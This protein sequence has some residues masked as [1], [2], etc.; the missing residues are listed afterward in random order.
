MENVYR[1]IRIAQDLTI[2]QLSEKMGISSSYINEIENGK[3]KASRNFIEKFSEATGIKKSTIMYFE[4]E[5]SEKNY[6]YQDL[7]LRILQKI[8]EM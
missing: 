7:L 5:N 1:L 3:K 8:V 2:S 4:E 6:K